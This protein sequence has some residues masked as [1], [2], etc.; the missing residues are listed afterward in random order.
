MV[1]ITSHY[2]NIHT[3]KEQNNCFFISLKAP[4]S[5]YSSKDQNCSQWSF[6]STIICYSCSFVTTSTII[7]N[8]RT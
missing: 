4:W 7:L 2:K 8:S 5:Y 3:I 6:S 1:T